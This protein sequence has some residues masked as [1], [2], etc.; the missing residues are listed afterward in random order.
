MKYIRTCEG[1][2]INVEDTIKRFKNNQHLSDIE[3]DIVKAIIT[4]DTDSDG[5]KRRAIKEA[6]T[7]EELLNEI[8][9]F[10]EKENGNYDWGILS[11]KDYQ[12][13]LKYE[14][15]EYV[16]KGYSAYGAI[17]TEKG[18]IYVAKMNEKGEWELV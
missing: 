16:S 14:I 18:L 15:D 3:C 10:K 1:K 17:W 11:A 5:Y 13:G 4:E 7:I 2:I 9:A 6:D 8:V 12:A